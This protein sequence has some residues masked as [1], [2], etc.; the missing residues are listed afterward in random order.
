MRWF[1]PGL[2]DEKEKF[3]TTGFRDSLLT[4][5]VE[6]GTDLEAVTKYLDAAGS[7]LDYRRYGETLFDILITGGILGASGVSVGD[8]GLA[9]ACVFASE[10]TMEALKRYEQVSSFMKKK[11]KKISPVQHT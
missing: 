10:N 2:L 3:D 1:G 8:G 6:A 5:L 9:P 11:E 4:G 7:K